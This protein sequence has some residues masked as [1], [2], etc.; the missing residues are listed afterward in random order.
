MSAAA[1]A[2]AFVEQHELTKR[3]QKVVAEAP[4]LASVQLESL[5]A[6]FRPDATTAS[7]AELADALT[8]HRHPDG[9]TAP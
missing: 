8:D 6:I 1:D 9:L 4:E 3:V 5:R 2:H 7:P